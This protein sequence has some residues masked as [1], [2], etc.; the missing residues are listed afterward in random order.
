MIKQSMWTGERR[1]GSRALA[2]GLAALFVSGV[3]PGQESGERYVVDPAQSDF[4]WLVYKAGAFSRFGHNHTIA[5]GDLSGN[6]LVNRDDLAKSQ[7]DLQFAVGQLVVDDPALRSTLGEDF[8]SVPKPDDI[9]GTRKNMLSER[10]LD[11][12]K[13]PQI[14]ITGT[15]PATSGATQELAVKVEMLGRVIDLKVPTNV[16]IDGDQLRATGEFELNHADLGMK[17]FSVMA[18]ALQ[19]GEKLSFTYDV[20]AQRATR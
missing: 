9:V 13:Y 10:V 15:G 2:V 3:A 11:G 6:V 19:V 20:R 8:S 5:V 17:P 7:F 14:R 1:F 16:T 12:E 18:G 4:H